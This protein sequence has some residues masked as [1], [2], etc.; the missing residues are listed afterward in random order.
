MANLIYNMVCDA[1]AGLISRRAAENLVKEALR[2]I[3]S[4]PE[5]VTAAEMQEL[6]RKGIFKRLQKVIPTMQAKGEIRRLLRRLDKNLVVPKKD[7]DWDDSEETGG[8]VLDAE[9]SVEGLNVLIAQEMEPLPQDLSSSPIVHNPEVTFVSNDAD[10]N[11][12]EANDSQEQEEGVFE[13]FDEDFSDLFDFESSMVIE[14]GEVYV[15]LGPK[16][17]LR[18]HAKQEE[19]LEKVALENGVTDVILSLRTDDLLNARVSRVDARSLCPTIARVAKGAAGGI[20]P[21]LIYI[22]S[23]EQLICIASLDDQV[24]LTVLGANHTNIGKLLTIIAGIRE[25][26]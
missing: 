1:F 11:R 17:V 15:S 6:L 13:P 23:E 5:R 8:Q 12:S 25:G 9:A 10:P 18:E 4:D 2:D 20:A 26:L 22:D 24:L 21:G 16:P 3:G 14:A 19:I 7:Q